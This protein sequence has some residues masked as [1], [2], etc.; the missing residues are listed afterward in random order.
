MKKIV[1][2]ATIL[3]VLLMPLRVSYADAVIPPGETKAELIA[4]IKSELINLIEQ[5]LTILEAELPSTPAS[6]GGGGGGG[7]SENTTTNN[8]NN[9]NG[10]TPI[11]TTLNGKFIIGSQSYFFG[12]GS[13][14][15]YGGGVNNESA[16][17]ILVDQIPDVSD[18]AKSALCPT[19][20]VDGS[21]NTVNFYSELDPSVAMA[22]F[23]WLK[24][25]NIDGMSPDVFV[26]SIQKSPAALDTTLG[27]IK[28]AAEA[29]GRVFYITFD[30][31][32]SPSNYD[33]IIESEWKHLADTGITTSPNYL[34]DNGKLVV[35]IWGAG[36]ISSP[37]QRPTDPNQM[38]QFINDLKTG[39]NGMLPATVI[40]GVPSHWR[41]LDGDSLTD[42][43]WLNVYES[44]DVLSP[45]SPGR[46]T[47]ISLEDAYFQNTMLPD[48][49]FAKEHNI[50]Y[51][52]VVWPSYSAYNLNKNISS[53]T[54]SLNQIPAEGGNFYWE[55]LYNIL[56][57]S[58]GVSAIYGAM[59]DD[60]N[61][62]MVLG[63]STETQDDLPVDINLLALD[64]D[65]Y[66]KLPN[67]WFLKITGIANTALRDGTTIPQTLSQALTFPG[68]T[69]LYDLL[70]GSSLS[71]G[72][73]IKSCNGNYE[74]VLQKAGNAVLYNISSYPHQVVWATPAYTYKKDL[75]A[76]LSLDTSGNLNLYDA[77][78]TLIWSSSQDGG[79]TGT[80]QGLSVTNNGNVVIYDTSN[81]PLW[82]SNPP[83][84]AYIKNK[85]VFQNE[86]ASALDAIKYIWDKILQFFKFLMSK[87]L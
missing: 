40:G 83:P 48:I 3:I 26:T 18:F 57:K 12:C 39:A 54:F 68:L 20:F 30:L 7:V 55:Q 82:T 15:F 33:Q 49:A 9:N 61:E 87:I 71:P 50:R 45:W 44:F 58:G 8:N 78:S 64:S 86:T 2:V 42:P 6:S 66:T 69:P 24:D 70:P 22:Q 1:S 79:I 85:N 76:L 75:G 19:P 35:E 23:G 73:Y 17:T 11:G 5:L 32:G 38:L 16:S 74:F 31:T 84:V 51:M 56:A 52:P 63:K 67:D 29:T 80:V 25:N 72:Q 47:S 13:H 28:T 65:G 34:N 43:A 46:F 37:N 81:N 60:Y 59:L 41:T 10:T 27:N 21:G 4:Q 14:W 62:G 53:A 36:L 77:T